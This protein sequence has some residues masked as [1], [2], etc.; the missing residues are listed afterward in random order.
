[1]ERPELE[2]VVA[3]L[4]QKPGVYQFKDAS[5]EILYIGKAVNLRN[6][7]RSYLADRPSSVKTRKLVAQIA[8][9]EC[10]VV[11]GELE[12]LVLEC[13]LIKQHRPKYNVRLKDDKHY[14]YI[15]VSLNEDWPRVDITRKLAR[16]GARY[17]GPY[18]DSRSVATTL[19]LLNK[20]FRY[21]RCNVE[22]TGS[23]S[24]GCLDYHIRRCLG[25]CMGK[26][27]R[28][29]YQAA[30]RQV[31]LFLEGRHDQIVRQLR[32]RMEAAAERLEFERAAYIRDQLEAIESVIQR[33]RVIST[34]MQD[35]DVIAIARNDGEACAEVFLIRGGKLIAGE[36]F[37]LENAAD[38]D[39]RTLMATFITQ[40]YDSAPFVPPQILVQDEVAEAKVIEQWLQSRRGAKV[41]IRVPRRGEK[42][43]LIKLAAANAASALEQMR[44]KWLADREKTSVALWE[45]ADHLDLAGPPRRI[46]CYDISNVQGTSSVGS[47]VVFENG[48]SARGSYRRFRIKTVEG[49][50][51][52][53]SLRE[54]LR[55]RF[56]RAKAGVDGWTAPDLVI[57][58]GGKGQLNAVREVF[59]ELDVE[60]V[61]L[62]SLA[63]ERE[64]IF[65]PNQSAPIVLPRASQSLYLVQRIRDE[66]HRF[67]LTYHRELHRRRT[68]RSPLDE[69]PGIGPKR[70]AALMRR[71]GTLQ[72][73][74]EASL[75]DLAAVPGMTRA[76]AAAL[77]EKL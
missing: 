35:E 2:Q 42:R 73:I 66:A 75:E 72:A 9:V 40:F 50:D 55:R 36:H 60:G 8:D 44:A 33:Q 3:A 32:R 69:V 24:R 70:R 67:A 61:S 45:L 49:A 43:E 39:T 14:P 19:A 11:N 62:A 27:S 7:V 12:A 65:V 29:E 74:R 4:P 1:M 68:L 64:E 77:K 5:G 26:V 28:E 25:P 57:V 58:D 48:Q 6:R 76:A 53:A 23:D 30:V 10:T 22:I 56:R 21:R 15:K 13:N 59:T 46:E 20:L 51:D 31:C 34:A 54:V 37:L 52:F 41:V 16:D 17:F 71:F 18:A 47:M 38:E 63:K